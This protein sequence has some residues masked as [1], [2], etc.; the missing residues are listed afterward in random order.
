MNR[1]DEDRLALAAAL[2]AVLVWGTGPLL[3]RAIDASTGT[4]VFWRLLVGQPFMIALAY[5]TGGRLSWTVFKAALVP[6]I[7][8]VTSMATGYAANHFTSIA[9]STLIGAMQ[10]AVLLAVAPLVFGTKS[11]RRQLSFAGVAIAG[12]VVVVLGAGHTSGASARGDLFALANLALWTVYFVRVKQIRDA[13]VHAASFLAAVF[14]WST[15]LVTPVV[16]LTSNDVADVRAHDWLMYVA[17]AVGSGVLGHGLMVWAQRH[18]DIRVASLLNLATPIVSTLGAWAI[19]HQRLQGLQLVGGA[20][21]LVGLAGVVQHHRT[22]EREAAV[23]EP[24][25]EPA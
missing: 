14:M 23:R 10:P 6:S 11:S 21:V 2:T 25:L 1:H 12:M 9:N 7:L 19:Y 8:F 15:V 13:G 4:I 5:L 17:L 24:A 18:L 16:L 3:V 20:A 22:T